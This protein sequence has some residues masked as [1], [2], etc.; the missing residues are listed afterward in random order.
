MPTLG[1]RL[2]AG[3]AVSALLLSSLSPSPA[4]DAALSSN[5]TV[6]SVQGWNRGRDWLGGEFAGLP[7]MDHQIL[8]AGKWVDLPEY[9]YDYR[10]SVDRPT[11]TQLILNEADQTVQVV[12]L[13]SGAVTKHVVHGVDS[14]HSV[15][16]SGYYDDESNSYVPWTG[17]PVRMPEDFYPSELTGAGYARSSGSVVSLRTGREITTL[18]QQAGNV[19]FTKGYLTYDRYDEESVTTESVCWLSL[20]GAVTTCVPVTGMSVRAQSNDAVLL[21]DEAGVNHTLVSRAGAKVK[22]TF[23]MGAKVV[24]CAGGDGAHILCYLTKG[25]S[26]ELRAVT[27]SGTTT[28]VARAPQAPAQVDSVALSSSKLLATDHRRAD[29]TP[30]AWS[31]SISGT[32]LGSETLL[33]ER[34]TLVFASAGRMMLGVRWYDRGVAGATLPHDTT[35]DWE[36]SELTSASGPYATFMGNLYDAL[37]MKVATGVSTNFGS[38]YNKEDVKAVTDLRNKVVRT[39][40]PDTQSVEQIWGPWVLT[41]ADNGPRVYNTVTRQTIQLSGWWT[42]LGDGFVAYGDES[43][44]TVRS[45]TSSATETLPGRVLTTLGNRIVYADAS[46]ALHVATLPFGGTSAP[47]LLGVM[48]NASASL[49]SPWKPQFDLTKPLKAGSITIKNSSGTVVATIP[50]PASTDGSIRGISWKGVNAN[51]AALPAGAYTWI[52]NVS[53]ATGKVAR[54]AD[55]SAAATD[56]LTVQPTAKPPVFTDVC[57]TANDKVTIPATAGVV[58]YWNGVAKAAGTYRASGTVTITAKAK[59]GYQLSGT[60]SWTKTFTNLKCAVPKAPTFADKCGTVNDKVMIPSATG[61]AYFWNNV[62]KGTGTYRASGT[63][64]ISARAKKGYQISGNSSWKKT[65]TKTACR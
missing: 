41:T 58:Y 40:P 7:V 20:P 4:A 32:S 52:L 39:L 51:G 6:P 19:G 30:T 5:I 12:D 23:P 65:F 56:S 9:F 59:K 27:A 22:V 17:A 1:R 43:T 42:H 33:P 8:R 11:S 35:S 45:L 53:D 49:A 26:A 18:P 48:G 60:A 25:D 16:S 34:A 28:F 44:S 29:D 38:L 37:G 61:V 2:G 64:T 47:L 31:R 36:W 46:G 63:V 50:V 14:A 24:G 21:A 13:A 3:A 54:S 15:T 62:A 55:G 57:G 10:S